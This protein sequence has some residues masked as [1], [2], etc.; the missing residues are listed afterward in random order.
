MRITMDDRL[1]AQ[2]T[3]L[4][5]LQISVGAADDFAAE[6]DSAPQMRRRK[7]RLSSIAWQ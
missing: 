2:C 6:D 5:G 4:E 3:T 7:V 1:R